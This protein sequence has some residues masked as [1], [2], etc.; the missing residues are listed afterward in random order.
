MPKSNPGAVIIFNSVDLHHVREEREA[1]IQQDRKALFRSEAVRERELYI[2]RQSDLTIV[3]SSVEKD[4][5]EATIPGTAVA[6]MPLFRKG[7]TQ[8]EGFEHR[9]GIGFVGG[10]GTLRMSM[11]SG[12]SSK[13]SGPKYTTSTPAPPV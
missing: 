3:V 10:F 6:V 4:I 13:R 11:P 2:A 9:R 8:V 7:S 1:R 5:I 12:I